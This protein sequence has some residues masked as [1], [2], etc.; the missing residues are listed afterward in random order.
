[1]HLR[2]LKMSV[3]EEDVFVGLGRRFAERAAAADAA[4]TPGQRHVN[5]ERRCVLK[6][7]QLAQYPSQRAI[8]FT[9]EAA[10][11]RFCLAVERGIAMDKAADV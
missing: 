6:I 9:D 2:D 5:A 7:Y 4:M 8:G 3:D 11:A 1:M 10:H